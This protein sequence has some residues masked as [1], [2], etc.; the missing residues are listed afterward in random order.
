MLNTSGEQQYEI[1]K[2]EGVQVI[3]IT[4]RSNEYNGIETNK[5][6]RFNLF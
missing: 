5:Y 2:I 6:S 1:K 4:K 3:K